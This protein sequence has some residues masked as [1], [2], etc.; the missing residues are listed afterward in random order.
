MYTIYFKDVKKQP[1]NVGVIET[2]LTDEEST[3]EHNHDFYEIF[4]ILH[5]RLQH[6]INGG[7]VQMETGDFYFIRP[8][9]CHYFRRI[10]KE[11]TSFVN[12]SFDAQFLTEAVQEKLFLK[13]YGQ[14]CSGSFTVM[15]FR[16]MR[17]KLEALTRAGRQEEDSD[18]LRILCANVIEEFFLWMKLNNKQLRSACPFWLREAMEKMTEGEAYIEGLEALLRF[19]GCTQEH[20]TRTMK[21]YCQ[22]TPSHYVNRLRIEKAKQLLLGTADS[23]LDISIQTGFESV[24]Y[25]N[26]MFQRLEGTTP[27]GYRKGARSIV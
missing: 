7:A 14:V 20:L 21:K 3:K 24:S 18:V 22:E 11:N 16:S 8:Q 27:S 9:D 5:G 23:V 13:V 6:Y 25:F 2:I 17:E 26:R 15:Q 1:F 4:L 12:I 19:S 10:G